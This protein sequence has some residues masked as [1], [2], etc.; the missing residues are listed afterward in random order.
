MTSNREIDGIRHAVHAER[1]A[2]VMQNSV[3]TPAVARVVAAYA[4][5]QS[6]KGRARPAAERDSSRC[7]SR[8]SGSVCATPASEVSVPSCHRH[9]PC[10][11]GEH[12]SASY[13]VQVEKNRRRAKRVEE[14]EQSIRKE[15]SERAALR[16]QLDD[17]IRLS[18]RL[19]KDS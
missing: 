5:E 6:Q 9:E 15:R 18:Q 13:R 3:P 1:N 19:V 17:V 11:A 16:N 2:V 8:A 14:L 10:D 4:A 12:A 7:S